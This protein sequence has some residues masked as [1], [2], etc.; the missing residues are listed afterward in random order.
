M[1][2]GAYDTTDPVAS[3]SAAAQDSMQL[4]AAK[5]VHDEVDGSTVEDTQRGT[6]LT[7][8]AERDKVQRA[9]DDAKRIKNKRSRG[10]RVSHQSLLYSYGSF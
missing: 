8:Q 4:H 2:R 10:I 1:G 5:K 7:E 9:E 6:R 3:K